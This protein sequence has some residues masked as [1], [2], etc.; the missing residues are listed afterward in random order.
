MIVL[1]ALLSVQH[2]SSFLPH[3]WLEQPLATV[4]STDRHIAHWHIAGNNAVV[5]RIAFAGATA[6]DTL[7]L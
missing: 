7:C 6:A 4:H 5:G 1:R 2:A 3:V